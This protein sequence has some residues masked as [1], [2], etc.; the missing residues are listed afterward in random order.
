VEDYSKLEIKSIAGGG[1]Y[2]ENMKS[3]SVGISKRYR[4][5]GQTS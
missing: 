3:L 1:S 5:V 2:F 4:Q